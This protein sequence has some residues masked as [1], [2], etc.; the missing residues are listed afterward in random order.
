MFLVH[1]RLRPRAADAA[2]NDHVAAVAAPRIASS[3]G[4]EHVVVHPRTD[5]ALVLGVYVS[6]PL[7]EHAEA[8]ARNAMQRALELEPPLPDWEITHCE[9]PL[10]TPLYEWPSPDVELD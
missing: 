4:V 1:V 2:S 5:G 8:R 10:I 6:A 3:A 7:L 9:V